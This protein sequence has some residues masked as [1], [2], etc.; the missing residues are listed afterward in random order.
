MITIYSQLYIHYVQLFKYI[1]F[2]WCCILSKARFSQG[3]KIK[4]MEMALV[5]HITTTKEGAEKCRQL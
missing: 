2:V 3:T 1:S 4:G 5:W